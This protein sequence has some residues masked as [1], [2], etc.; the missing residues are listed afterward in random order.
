M[1]GQETDN[2]FRISHLCEILETYLPQDQIS[3]VYQSYLLGAEAHDG[4]RRLSGEPYI[5][6]PISVAKI[7][8]EMHM[9]HQSIMAAILHDVIEDTG[10]AKEQ[11]AKRFGEPIAEMVDGVSKL[12]NIQFESKAEAQ[13]ENFRKMMLAMTRDIRVILIKLA[14]RLHN[15]RTLGVM[16][17]DKRRRIARETL[18]IYAPIANRLGMNRMRLELEDLGFAAMYPLRSKILTSSLKKARGNRKE[19]VNK[20]EDT[21]RQRL[22]HDELKGKVVG[23]EKH[24]YSIYKKMKDKHLAFSEVMDVYAMRIIV[25]SVDSCY[26]VLGAVHNLYTPMP[27]RFKDYIAIPKANGYQSLHTV[28]FSPYGV[29]SEI[30][31]RTEDMHRVAETGIAAHWTYKSTNDSKNNAEMR[32]RQWLHDVLEIQQKAGNS[33]E[34]LENVKVNLFPDEVYVFTPKG[35]IL[36]LPRG[37][38]AVDF[39]YRVHTDV[40]NQCVAVKIDRRLMPLSTELLNSQTIEI[41]SSKGAQPNPAWLDFVFTAKAQ[42]NI[43][44]FLKNLQKDEATMLGT[45]LLNKS[46]AAHGSSMGQ[47]SKEQV[48]RVLKEYNFNAMEDMY[49]EIGLGNQMAMVIARALLSSEDDVPNQKAGTSLPL[50]IRGTEGAVVTFAKCCRPIPGDSIIGFVTSGRGIVVHTEACKNVAEYK[51][52]PEKWVEVAWEESITNEFAVD[53]RLLVLNKRGALAT[54]ASALSDLEANIENVTI[55]ERDGLHNT[56]SFT[57]SIRDRIHLARVLRHLRSLDLVVRINR[58]QK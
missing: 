33:I 42:A 27:G 39:A 12:T 58:Q 43:R 22:V 32:A 10:T 54:I 15:M 17:P 24:I 3:L 50:V 52:R 46:L 16:R 21:I 37:A 55:D 34:F 14:D 28:L 36:V 20:I 6:H 19:V 8:A 29:A 48:K 35:D 26:R 9:D 30:Q 38:T 40:G 13:A 47:I 31:I 2:E 25:D 41:I 18:E 1:N 53:L 44:S 5:T 45:R 57:V 7:L 23:R 49:S 51:N 4:Q 11:I 56:M